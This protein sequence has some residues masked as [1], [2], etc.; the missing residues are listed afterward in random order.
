[1]GFAPF[2]TPQIALV[3]YV[4][5]AGWGGRAAAAIAGLLLEKY[6]TGKVTRPHMEEY[7]LGGDFS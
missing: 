1:M 4:E 5:N 6:L 2:E 3:V 7:V